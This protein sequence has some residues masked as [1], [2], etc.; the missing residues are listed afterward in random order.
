[1]TSDF[2]A[3]YTAALNVIE[4]DTKCRAFVTV[5]H[6]KFFSNG[7]DLAVCALLLR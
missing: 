4:G 6:G 1:M 2:I 3:S 7:L 5:G